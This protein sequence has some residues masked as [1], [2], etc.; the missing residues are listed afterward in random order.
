[1]KFSQV[2]MFQAIARVHRRTE[3][4]GSDSWM[5]TSR[6]E[7]ILRVIHAML[8]NG[9]RIRQLPDEDEIIQAWVQFRKQTKLRLTIEVGEKYGFECFYSGRAS[10][11]CSNDIDLDRIK[12]ESRGGVYEPG[13]CIIACSLH[14]RARGDKGIEEFLLCDS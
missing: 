7:L 14:N 13:N 3:K 10:G 4:P 11:E 2:P 6:P 9:V 5:T 8:Y 12:P 1:M